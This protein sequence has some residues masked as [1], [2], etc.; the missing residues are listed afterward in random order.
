VALSNYTELQAAIRT[1]MGNVSTGGV[2]A[3]ALTDCIARAESKINRRVRLREMEQLSTATY[4]TSS[5]AV[6]DRRIALPSDYVEWLDLR[7]KKASEDDTAYQEAVFVA[8]ERIHEYYGRNDGL[9]YTLRNQ[10]EFSRSTGGVEYE[11]MMH[12]LKRWDIATDATNWLL[13]NYPDAYLY[14]SCM[15][16]AIHMRE[17]DAAQGYKILFDE[18]LAELDALSERGRDDSQ[19]DVSDLALLTRR[20]TF[21]VING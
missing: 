3:D 4:Q 19:L 18:A 21:N 1:E 15:E 11:L 14:G 20:N 16:V 9:W 13:T 2:S 5:N 6:E 7:W 8:P 10:I 17:K 12:F